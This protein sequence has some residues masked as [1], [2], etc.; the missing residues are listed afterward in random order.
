MIELLVFIL[1]QIILNVLIKKID[2]PRISYLFSAFSVTL[3][4]ILMML[5]PYVSW[6]ITFALDPPNSSF[7]CGNAYLGPVLFQWVFGI[8]LVI[9]VQI[10]FNRRVHHLPLLIDRYERA[11]Q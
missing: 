10:F 11:K 4:T 5:Y 2:I 7:I 6:H 1:I 8:P 3:F 9:I